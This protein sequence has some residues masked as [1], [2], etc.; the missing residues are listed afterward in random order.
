MYTWDTQC[1]NTEFEGCRRLNKEH[2]LEV[3][4]VSCAVYNL[5][6]CFLNLTCFWFWNVAMFIKVVTNKLDHYCGVLFQRRT[7]S[8]FICTHSTL[9]HQSVKTGNTLT[10]LFSWDHIIQTLVSCN[11]SGLSLEQSNLHPVYTHVWIS[12]VYSLRDKCSRWSIT[13]VNT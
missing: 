1:F 2:A 11:L 13:Y 6:V 10:L 12:E 8:V 7:F 5:L 9:F 3:I 4:K